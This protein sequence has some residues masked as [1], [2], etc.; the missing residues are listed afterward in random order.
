MQSR[1]DVAEARFVVIRRNDL[2]PDNVVYTQSMPIS[3]EGI[4]ATQEPSRDSDLRVPTNYTQLTIFL[5]ATE[6]I[7]DV[8]PGDTRPNF[9][10]LCVLIIYD[11]VKLFHRNEDPDGRINLRN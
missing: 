7:V 2:K 4:T 5:S 8:T 11:L 6:E 1:V 3:Q 10:S 9:E